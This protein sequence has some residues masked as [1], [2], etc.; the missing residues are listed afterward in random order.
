[1]FG[2][3]KSYKMR[4]KYHL[5]KKFNFFKVF[6]QFFGNNRIYKMPKKALST[7]KF[8]FVKIKNLCT[9]LEGIEFMSLLDKTSRKLLKR[10]LL[11]EK[12]LSKI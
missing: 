8:N 11:C 7:K 10:Y 6:A 1:M 5:R 3:N 2:K 9:F 4:K 12:S